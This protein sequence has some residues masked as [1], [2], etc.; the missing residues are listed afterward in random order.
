MNKK[1]IREK[2]HEL[3]KEY[4]KYQEEGRNNIPNKTKI[5]VG[6]PCYG[7]EEIVSAVD[8]LLDLRLSQG[9]KVGKFEKDFSK[10]IGSKYGIAVNS[11]SSANLLAI[12]ALLKT[13]RVK[14]GSEV[15]V[16]AATF[17][18]VVSPILQNGLIPVFVDVDSETYNIDPDRVKNA[19]NKNTCLIMVVHSLGCPADI[20]EILEI[21]KESDIPVMEDCCEA[22]GASIDGKKI[23]SFGLI[24]T[25]SFFVAHNMTTGEGGMILTDDE[26]LDKLLRSIREFGRLREVEVDRPR[27][28]YTDACLKDYDERYVFENVGYNVRM[29]DVTA[30][31]GIEQ[32]KKLDLLNAA[33]VEIANYF[34][35]RLKKYENFL[36]LPKI[37]EKSF[38]S[39]YGYPILVKE[40][41]PFLR[42]DLVRFL[43]QHKI[44]TR[45][46]MGGN[47]ALQ[48]AY[49]NENIKIVGDL[50]NTREI[51]N[52]AFFIGCHP[53][54]DVVQRE[55]VLS[56]FNNFFDIC[57]NNPKR[58]LV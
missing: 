41:A 19:I 33:R 10:Y 28:Y 56:T 57:L 13:D 11:G 17:A 29:T 49:R 36:Q 54:I 2:I 46:F 39:F 8:S 1:E 6:F 27:F 47:L 51:L 18:T 16:P 20:K 38:H 23:G 3:I 58:V 21:S 40:K 55:Y 31:L 48:P 24:S 22:H 15:I 14:P 50:K 45:A 42:T 53:Y 5:G 44:E 7:H 25:Y 30:S 34:A 43:E 32:L 37:P 52:N 26:E 35:D 9:E 12:S 4:F